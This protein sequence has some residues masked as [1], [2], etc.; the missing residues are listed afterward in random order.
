MGIPHDYGDSHI[1]TDIHQ[2][3]FEPTDLSRSDE[4]TGLATLD[5]LLRSVVIRVSVDLAEMYFLVIG[6]IYFNLRS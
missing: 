4:P 1:G 2:L 5:V 3:E 6:S